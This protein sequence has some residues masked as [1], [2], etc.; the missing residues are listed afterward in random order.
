MRSETERLVFTMATPFLF[1]SLTVSSSEGRG[2][3]YCFFVLVEIYWGLF[4]GS[5]W[6][7][8]CLVFLMGE[9]SFLV[10]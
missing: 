3:G 9:S 7:K 2:C 4:L 6:E 5:Y 1:L 8:S 10:V